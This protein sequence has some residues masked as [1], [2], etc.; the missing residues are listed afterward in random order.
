ML[1]VPA[2]VTGFVG[3]TGVAPGAVEVSCSCSY[4]R[5]VR[6]VMIDTVPVIE[7]AGGS[8]K[9]S[10]E[11]SLSTTPSTTSTALHAPGSAVIVKGRVVNGRLFA[12]IASTL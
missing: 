11:V 1:Y 5:M 10:T 12:P 4:G 8:R 7:P 6:L 2:P 3:P 9:T